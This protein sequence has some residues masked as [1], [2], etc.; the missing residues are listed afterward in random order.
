VVY[1][2]SGFRWS[3]FEVADVNVWVSLGM[4]LFFLLLCMAIV[5]W[6]F[7]TGYKLKQ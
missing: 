5:S 6:M 4:I 2:V 3:F 1:L 7:K